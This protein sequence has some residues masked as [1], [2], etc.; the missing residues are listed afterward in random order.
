MFSQIFPD[1][2]IRVNTS[3][4]RF[5]GFYIAENILSLA[6]PGAIAAVIKLGGF[7]AKDQLLHGFPVFCNERVFIQQFFELTFIQ[8][9][10]LIGHIQKVTLPAF[11]FLQSRVKFR[12]DPEN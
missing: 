10:E 7:D 8:V 6:G 11:Q 1:Q 12:F 2:S 3:R 9:F 5:S 4:D